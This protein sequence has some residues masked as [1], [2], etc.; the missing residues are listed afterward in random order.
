MPAPARPTR[1][2]DAIEALPE[3]VTGELINGQLHTQPRPSGAHA[4]ASSN[5]GAELLPPY[6]RGRGGPGG[7]WILDEPEVHFRRDT[8]VLVPDLAGWRRER[9]PE[10]P[11]DQRFE[12]VPDWVCEILSPATESRDREVKLPVYARYGVPHAWLIDPRTQVLE[13]YALD[14]GEWRQVALSHAED[15]VTAE[16]FPEAGFRLGD[17]WR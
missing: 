6:A 11:E 8:E 2:Y 14:D 13:A 10:L 7:W 15:T 9:M 16:P 17:L 4:A 12:V 5:L 1:L 3:G